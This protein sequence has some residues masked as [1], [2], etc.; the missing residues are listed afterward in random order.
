MLLEVRNVDKRG[1]SARY[2]VIVVRYGRIRMRNIAPECFASTRVVTCA[3]AALAFSTSTAD[4][5]LPKLA[6]GLHSSS[7]SERLYRSLGEP[8]TV[9][10]CR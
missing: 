5:V 3:T 8:L 6:I 1:N 7:L 4:K 9:H 10:F 2:S